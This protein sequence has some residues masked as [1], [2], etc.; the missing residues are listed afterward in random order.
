MVPATES[1]NILPAALV[2]FGAADEELEAG[3]E[4]DADAALA[5]LKTPP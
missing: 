2:A 4:L 1:I 5:A 3:A